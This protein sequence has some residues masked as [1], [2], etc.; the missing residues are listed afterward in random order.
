M[1][2]FFKKYTKSRVF[3]KMFVNKVLKTPYTSTIKKL[4][5]NFIFKKH[6]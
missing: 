5:F 6:T 2:Y 3:V 4:L 1:R